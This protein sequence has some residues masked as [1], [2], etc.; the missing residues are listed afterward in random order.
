MKLSDYYK[1]LEQNPEYV[2][3]EK[4]LRFRFRL[5]NAVLMARIEKGWSQADLAQAVGTKQANISQIEGGL[6]N[7]TLDFIRRLCDVLGL[8]MNFLMG[9]GFSL[10]SR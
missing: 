8:E 5:A 7:P 10:A 1:K 3:A 9:D 4:D 6:A 2:A